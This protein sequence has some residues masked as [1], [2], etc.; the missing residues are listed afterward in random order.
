MAVLLES[1]VVAPQTAGIELTVVVA[2]LAVATMKTEKTVKI[3]AMLRT[4]KTVAIT[5]AA[6]SSKQLRT[7]RNNNKSFD[8]PWNF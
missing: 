3:A 7:I 2:A 8:P 5:N 1:F 6:L 4:V